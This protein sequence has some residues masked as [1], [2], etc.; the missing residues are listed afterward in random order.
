MTHFETRDSK[1]ENA[2]KSG[3]LFLLQLVSKASHFA[4]LPQTTP[5]QLQLKQNTKKKLQKAG[6]N[7]DIKTPTCDGAILKC[8]PIGPQS[9]QFAHVSSKVVTVLREKIREQADL[10]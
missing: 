8:L 1:T 9:G 5:Y 3:S 7:S 6:L 2:S 4:E 10:P